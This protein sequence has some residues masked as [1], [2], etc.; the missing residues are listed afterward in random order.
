MENINIE[1]LLQE[2]VNIINEIINKISKG[3]KV[4]PS[5]INAL[6]KS[7]DRISIYYENKIGELNDQRN[8]NLKNGNMI[9]NKELNKKVTELKEQIDL[10]DKKY[11]T[12]IG[13]INSNFS[14]YDAEKFKSVLKGYLESFEKK[15][16]SITREEPTQ[17]PTQTMP[18]TEQTQT[19][20]RQTESDSKKKD[21]KEMSVEELLQEEYNVI[22]NM[23]NSNRNFTDEMINKLTGIVNALATKYKEEMENYITKATNEIREINP[24][25]LKRKDY[26]SNQHYYIGNRWLPGKAANDYSRSSYIEPPRY[27]GNDNVQE[28][29]DRFI[30]EEDLGRYNELVQKHDEVYK[31]QHNAIAPYRTNPK[32][33]NAATLNYELNK[34]K[35][36]LDNKGFSITKEQSEP[37]ITEEEKQKNIDEYVY[38][39]NTLETLYKEA[40]LYNGDQKT[41]NETREQLKREIAEI[42]SE[43]NSKGLLEEAKNAYNKDFQARRNK[44]IEQYKNKQSAPDQLNLEEEIKKL[45]SDIVELENAMKS[46][47]TNGYLQER[48]NLVS[49]RISAEVN[50]LKHYSDSNPNNAELKDKYETIKSA[51]K[52]ADKIQKMINQ[53]QPITDIFKGIVALYTEMEVAKQKGILNENT[54]NLISTLNGLEI[55]LGE[56][57]E[58]LKQL[59]ESKNKQESNEVN[60]NQNGLS[61]VQ[62]GGG[63]VPQTPTTKSMQSLPVIELPPA[64]EQTQTILP[65]S[66]IIELPPAQE[67]QQELPE[68]LRVEK[69]STW[70]WAKDNKKKVLIIAGLS[71]VAVATVV[72]FQQLIPA[73]MSAQKA[74]NV[75]TICKSMISN[76][77]NWHT[78]VA[79]EQAA[80]HGANTALGSMIETLTGNKA[81]FEVGSGIWKF[82]QSGIE[83][84][85][86]AKETALAAAKASKKVITLS[87][88]AGALGL[89][90]LGSI[91][92]GSLLNGRSSA[93]GKYKENMKV[94]SAQVRNNEVDSEFYK[95]IVEFATQINNDNSLTESEKRNLKRKITILCDKAEEMYQENKMGGH[96]R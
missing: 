14:E 92:F 83:L 12:Y 72:A 34:I 22:Q 73:I 4:V 55:E 94:F 67:T 58:K 66:D 56:K 95:N 47:I 88:T 6:N 28:A 5:D 62:S 53:K 78:A 36:K 87:R 61:N 41:F 31:L 43:L 86:F 37:I 18:T 15:D 1:Q 24:E 89:A 65:T 19:A 71:A 8:E 26:D 90:G 60:K 23:L 64:Q 16:N 63:L 17:E 42:E 39:R 52:T 30:K 45:Q 80:L 79:S 29:S 38:A 48:I 91:G 7:C 20:I 51:S 54:L 44:I 3:E 75:S 69:R 13:P 2:R 40:S 33:S 68:E 85:A 84:S 35:E 11:E 10:E 76:A 49:K 46:Y 81:V 59:T 9:E 74:N 57:A 27:M 82:G 93:Y 50:R 32:N 96:S 25:L 77:N 70:Q 21:Y